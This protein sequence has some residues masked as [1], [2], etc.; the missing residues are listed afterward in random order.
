MKIFPRLLILLVALL[1]ALAIAQAPTRGEQLVSQ[2]KKNLEDLKGIGKQ[3]ELVEARL[4]RFEA[5]DKKPVVKHGRGRKVDL[6]VVKARRYA[7]FARHGYK[8][9]VVP[10][11]SV[12]DTFDCR[13]DGGFKVL[14]VNDQGQCF[15]A[16]TPVTVATVSAGVWNASLQAQEPIERIKVGDVV[17]SDKGRPKKVLNVYERSIDERLYTL[18]VEGVARFKA[19]GDH[20][21]LVGE[22]AYKP[23]RLIS[24]EPVGVLHKDFRGLVTIRYMLASAVRDPAASKCTV[25][26]LGVEDDRGYVAGGVCVHNCGDCFGVSSFDGCSMALIYAG[27]LPLDGSKGRLSS[28]Y[29]LDNP[30]AFQGGC[31][32][33]DEGQVIDFVKTNGAPLTSDYGP[34]T[35]SPGQPKP[36]AGMKFYK[37]QDYGFADVTVG[38]GGVASTALMQAAIAKNGPISVAFDAGGCDA[39]QWPQVMTAGGNNVDHAVLCIGWKT[40]N[41]KVI[42]LG[43]NQWGDWGGPGGTFWIQEGSYSWGTEAMWVYAGAP[44][45]PPPGPPTPPAPGNIDLILKDATPAQQAALLAQMGKL[46]PAP[47][48]GIVITPDM[49]LLQ[50]AEAIVAASKSKEPPKK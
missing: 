45:P 36:T 23:L 47:P 50:F 27:L 1:P 32:G 5:Q 22:G 18:Q 12:P 34:Y 35:A 48:T 16:G 7:A 15:P 41:G 21:V 8:S 28:Q 26:N 24:N 31:N 44:T 38:A 9:M 33:G 29:G 17:V 30:N 2:G 43:M 14:P 11:K 37:I 25:Y 20:P 13:T 4:V 39:Y 3:L 19:T 6:A 42:F 10:L 49:T 40:V 46:P